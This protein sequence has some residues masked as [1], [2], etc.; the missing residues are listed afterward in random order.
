MVCPAAAKA[1][2]LLFLRILLSNWQTCNAGSAW[3]AASW[4]KGVFEASTGNRNRLEAARSIRA[5]R[6]GSLETPGGS[7]RDRL[8]G[9][10]AIGLCGGQ[11]NAAH[12]SA[13]TLRDPIFDMSGSVGAPVRFQHSTVGRNSRKRASYLA[14]LGKEKFMRHV[15]N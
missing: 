8:R 7:S 9:E 12:N 3:A 10:V 6:G 1:G 4:R 11:V 2:W 15:N 5:L 14:A 13:S